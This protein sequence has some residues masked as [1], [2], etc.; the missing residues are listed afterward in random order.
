ML[1]TSFH[2]LS[3]KTDYLLKGFRTSFQ[4]FVGMNSDNLIKKKLTIVTLE[5]NTEGHLA[6]ISD[7]NVLMCTC[8][9][10][11]VCDSIHT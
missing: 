3:H 5:S 9:N 1:S 11:Y 2:D 8:I 10:I 4:V 6:A 7:L